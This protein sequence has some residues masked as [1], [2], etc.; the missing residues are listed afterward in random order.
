M[1][2]YLLGLLTPLAA[3]AIFAV[4]QWVYFRLAE[5][6]RTYR[7]GFRHRIRARI[8][9]ATHLVL[10][11]RFL[12]IRLP[13]GVILV[14]ASTLDYGRPVD[15]DMSRLHL[16]EDRAAIQEALT[17]VVYECRSA[18]GGGADRG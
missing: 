13:G 18:T 17:T 9:A 6:W 11:S 12:R 5:S 7:P 10:T 2:N 8:D 14:Y 16:R 4:G 15:G 3:F 1:G